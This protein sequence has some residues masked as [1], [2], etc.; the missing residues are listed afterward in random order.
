[1]ENDEKLVLQFIPSLASVLLA[2]EKQKGNALTEE[3]AINIRDTSNCVAVTVEM[4]LKAEE[5]RGYKDIDP[6]NCWEEWCEMCKSL[7]P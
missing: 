1:M 4:F 7:N 3:E 6:E 2:A 5:S